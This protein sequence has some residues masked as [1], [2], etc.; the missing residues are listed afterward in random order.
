MPKSTQAASKPLTEAQQREQDI[1][2]VLQAAI[3]QHQAGAHADAQ[4]LYEVIVNA[5]PEQADA[6]FGLAML[7]VQMDQPTEALPHFEAAL[8]V[9]P[10]N[11]DC[12]VNYIRALDLLGHSASAWI[13]VNIAQKHGINSEAFTWQVAQL[14][15]PPAQFVAAPA[16]K[17]KARRTVRKPKAV[18]EEIAKEGAEESAVP[19][20]VVATPKPRVRRTVRKAEAVVGA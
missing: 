17:P 18:A 5:A 8:D 12:W 13:A 3:A 15:P 14:A 6:R 2:L 11:A 1:A 7:M 16:A 20:E 9:N 4:A 19:L 10:D